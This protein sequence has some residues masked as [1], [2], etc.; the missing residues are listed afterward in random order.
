MHIVGMDPNKTT[1]ERAFELAR[2][3]KYT[4]VSDLKRDVIAEGYVK[5]QLDGQALSRQLLQL[6][7]ASRT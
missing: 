7:R 1:L 4:Q 3:G 2:S 5:N 6:I